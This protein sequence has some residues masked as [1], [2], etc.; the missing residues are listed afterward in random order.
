MINLDALNVFFEVARS[1]N[2]GTAAKKLNVT[3]SALSQRLSGL[4][5]QIGRHLFVRKRAGMELSEFGTELHAICKSLEKN[6][7]QINNWLSE[8]QGA[9]R[10]TLRVSSIVSHVIQ[11]LPLFLKGF[12]EKYPDVNFHI[13]SNLSLATEEQV[14]SRHVDVG[15]I[16]GGAKTTTLKHQMLMTGNDVLCVC[17]PKYLSTLDRWE[18]IEEKIQNATILWHDAPMSK[19]SL[20]IRKKF[21]L[22]G[23]RDTPTLNLPDMMVCKEYALR[24][25]GLAFVAKPVIY[26][27]LKKGD[28][29]AL[30]EMIVPGTCAM[31]YRDEKY[32]PPLQRVFREEYA[33]FCKEM[34]KKE[35]G[36][37][38]KM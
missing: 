28:L 21:Y 20:K 38:M 36:L 29:V 37:W 23:Q 32:E 7:I 12:L 11:L 24:G 5:A 6:F 8:Q 10:G 25:L 22:T 30:P 26:R 2:L 4:E 34:E 31:V 9:I 16:M 1:G 18:S 15:I 27:D 3:P 13:K 35:E 19:T 17:T 14:L 33:A